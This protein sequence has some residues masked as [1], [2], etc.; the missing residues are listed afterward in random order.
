MG[1]ASLA[2]SA[3]GTV[4]TVTE[5]GHGFLLV[6]KFTTST[7]SLGSPV[8]TNPSICDGS[9]RKPEL[10]SPSPSSEA[11]ASCSGVRSAS[12]WKMGGCST[13]AGGTL[14][15]AVHPFRSL[16]CRDDRF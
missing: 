14:V 13:A 5:V 8:C 4:R 12:T 11:T 10:A 7:D 1:A 16:D 15:I 2:T 9:T 6:P 3:P